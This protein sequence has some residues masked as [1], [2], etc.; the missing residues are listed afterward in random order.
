MLN[1]LLKIEMSTS[2]L[3]S[4]YFSWY[5]TKQFYSYNRILCYGWIS[6]PYVIF[7]AILLKSLTK[8]V[9]EICIHPRRR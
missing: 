7:H 1:K 9:E 5:Y 3:N 6:T 8:T 4:L 2:Y